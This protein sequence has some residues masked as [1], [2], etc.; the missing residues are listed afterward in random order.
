MLPVDDADDIELLRNEDVVRLKVRVAEGRS[1]EA[2][3]IWNE[4]WSNSHILSESLYV[5]FGH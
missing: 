5:F 2:G 1:V 4:I 3:I